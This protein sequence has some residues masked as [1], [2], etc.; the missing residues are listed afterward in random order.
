MI[1]KAKQVVK[2]H[3]KKVALSAGVAAIVMATLPALEGV[4][5]RVY[6]DIVGVPTY[7]YGETENPTWGRT[8]TPQECRDLLIARLPDYNAH[9]SRCVKVP[10]TDGMTAAMIMFAYNVG[11]GAFCRS[12]IVRRINEGHPNPCPALMAWTMAGGQQVL[13]LVNRRKIEVKV[14]NMPG[15]KHDNNG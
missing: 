9:V 1:R 12:S 10:M 5:Y 8:Y 2:N 3:P 6:R 13:G 4:R 14:C 7:C 11:G 15:E